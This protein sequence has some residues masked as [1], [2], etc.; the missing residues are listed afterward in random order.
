MYTLVRSKS[1]T[2]QYIIVESHMTT[3]PRSMIAITLCFSPLELPV[4]SQPAIHGSM[5]LYM[6]EMHTQENVRRYRC[7]DCEQACAR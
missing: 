7:E 6:G 3:I 1:V 5:E 4:L 2:I